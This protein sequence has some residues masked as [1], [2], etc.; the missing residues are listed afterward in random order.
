[1]IPWVAVISKKIKKAN[2]FQ[3]SLQWKV[4]LFTEKLK[5]E[6]NLFSGKMKYFLA[7]ALQF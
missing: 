6:S 2:L 5:I 1:M 7:I 4:S 3:A